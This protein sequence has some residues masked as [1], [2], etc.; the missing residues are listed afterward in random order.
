MNIAKV[1]P[2]YYE[3]VILVSS[4]IIRDSTIIVGYFVMSEKSIFYAGQLLKYD[5]TK[6]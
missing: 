5:F 6:S 3:S 4:T 2:K 1:I